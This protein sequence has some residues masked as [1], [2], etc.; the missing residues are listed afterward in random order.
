MIACPDCGLLQDLPRLSPGTSG[1]CRLCDAHLERTSGRSI[2]ATLGCSLAAFFL[3]FPANLLPLLRVGVFGMHNQSRLGSGIFVLWNHEWI[4]LSALIGAFA[5]IL[6]FVRFGLLSTVL[7]IIWL[8]YRPSWIGAGF[9]W[10]LWLDI[11]AMPDVFLLGCFVGYFRLVKAPALKVYIGVGGYCFLA[12]AV[13]AMISRAAID[14]RTV[15][16]AIAPEAEPSPGEAVLSCTTCD[17]V[18]P[19]RLEGHACPRCGAR[20]YTRKPFAL[21]HATALTAAA[22]ILFFPANFLPMNTSL[23]IGTRVN[24]TIL[25]GVKELFKAGLWPLGVIVFCAS[26]GIP[27]LKIGG[28]A[29]FIASVRRRSTKHL[30]AKTKLYRFVDEIGRWSNMD[31]FTLAVFVPLMTF[32]PLAASNAAWGATAFIAVVVLTLLASESF[33]PRLMWDVAE[34]RIP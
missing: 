24:Y 4:I 34:R 1:V 30:V 20:L 26:I 8:G 9:R 23:Q 15:W 5:V 22:F 6:P 21:L 18:L 12:A 16:R 25:R 29:W 2:T 31:P 33:D 13:L 17:L 32:P 11:W 27:A 10:A 19:V 14:R 7:G 3:L 28:M